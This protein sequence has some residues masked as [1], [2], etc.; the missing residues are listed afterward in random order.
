MC[1]AVAIASV[2]IG[3]DKFKATRRRTDHTELTLRY[4][5]PYIS[6]DRKVRHHTLPFNCCAVAFRLLH[7]VRARDVCGEFK[8]QYWL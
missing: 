8:V 4:A 1:G 3:G 7:G 2:I 6:D 5:R